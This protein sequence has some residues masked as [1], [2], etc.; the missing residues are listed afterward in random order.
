MNARDTKEPKSESTSIQSGAMF[1]RLL[2]ATA[3][4]VVVPAIAWAE[5]VAA[6]E[7]EVAAKSA[8][9]SKKPAAKNTMPMFKPKNLGSPVTRLGGATRSTSDLVPRTEAL[10]PE[11]SGQTIA[12]Q[13]A[14][15]WYLA[16]AT[17]HRIDFT[18]IRV[19]DG[20]TLVEE[21]LPSGLVPGIQRVALSDHGVK[22]EPGQSYQWFVAVVPRP[23]QPLYNRIV[24]GGIE[25]VAASDALKEKLDATPDTEDYLVLSEAGLWYDAFDSLSMLIESSPDD[26]SLRA[27]RTAL[28]GQVGLGSVN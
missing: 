1:A 26:A 15:Y 2:L 8:E 17:E 25:R 3:L 12:S 22:L 27:Q 13:P 24:G 28:L 21:T 6:Q 19:D 23:E 20:T 4:A 11:V 18:L 14:I 9:K 10:V 7:T 16:D 5:T